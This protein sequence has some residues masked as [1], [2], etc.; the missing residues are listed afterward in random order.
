MRALLPLLAALAVASPAAASNLTVTFHR[1]GVSG[2]LTLALDGPTL[3]REVQ[4]LRGAGRRFVTASE[5]ARASGD[6]AAITFDDGYVDVYDVAFPVLRELGVKATFFVITDKVGHPGYVSWTQLRE[7]Q[8]A[9]WEIGS[10]T[11]SHAA[12][13]DLTPDS[14]ER[15]LGGSRDELARRGFDAACVA[16]PFG[17][18][19]ARV[20]EVAARFYS[21]AF[22]TSFGVN[23]AATDPLAARRPLGTPLDANLGL[24]WRANSG[25]D[26][27]APVLALGLL[28]TLEP[29][30]EAGGAPRFGNAARFELLGDGA[31]SFSAS[32]EARVQ[33]FVARDGAFVLGARTARGVSRFDEVT[34]GVRA[35]GAAFAVGLSSEGP[36]VGA[37]VPL[38]GFGEAWGR[39]SFGARSATLGA[40]VLPFDYAR[41]DVEWNDR[42]GFAVEGTYALPIQEGEGRPFRV[43][44]GFDEG[45]YGGVTARLGSFDVT[46]TVG[47]RGVSIGVNAKW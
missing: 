43:L 25:V 26:T 12:L 24:A 7:L 37:A 5:V 34:L 44:A 16:Y 3:R 21:C 18:H 13:P 9:G 15:E 19:D 35:L 10:H 29:S 4:S 8:A 1:V 32:R 11:R 38:G 31:W 27:R 41:L 46:G 28:S 17:L 45:A 20:R 40:S 6:T 22:T 33:S 36:L 2:G 39:F 42:R 14:L 47:A 30:G 23:D